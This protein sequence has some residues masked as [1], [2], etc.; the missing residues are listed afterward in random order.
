M[1]EGLLTL[2]AIGI[3]VGIMLALDRRE[4]ARYQ[5]L[6][7]TE[8]ELAALQAMREE[9]AKVLARDRERKSAA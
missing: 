1:I 6:V 3:G 8:E 2:I 4:R 7:W 9:R 5:P